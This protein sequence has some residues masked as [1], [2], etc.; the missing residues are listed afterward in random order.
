MKQTKSVKKMYDSPVLE[1]VK[2]SME[3]SIATSGGINGA[4]LFEQIWGG[5]DGL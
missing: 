2:F 5:G 3:D 1:V 4:S